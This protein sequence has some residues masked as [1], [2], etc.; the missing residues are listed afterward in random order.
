MCGVSPG[1][2]AAAGNHGCSRC[3]E[4]PWKE[5]AQGHPVPRFPYSQPYLGPITA[6]LQS[7]RGPH[8]PAHSSASAT[9]SCQGPG[10]TACSRCCS[11]VPRS[12]WKSFKGERCP[13]WW[14]CMSVHVYISTSTLLHSGDQ[15]YKALGWTQSVNAFKDQPSVQNRR[16]WP[17]HG[18]LSPMPIG[19]ARH[20]AQV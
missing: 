8:R 11:S 7:N 19:W 20:Q 12:T 3:S 16:N 9:S 2:M 18:C 13:A 1:S 4:R 5:E 6:H 15:S 14:A 10:P 17:K